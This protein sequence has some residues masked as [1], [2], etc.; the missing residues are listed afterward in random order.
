MEEYPKISLKAARI[1]AGMKQADAAREIRVSV[2][3]LKRYEHGDVI[4]RADV[5]ERMGRAYG[6]PIWHLDLNGPS[7][8]GR[9]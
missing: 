8:G 4:P 6:I 9:R 5:L 3:A 7:G 1:N 2:P